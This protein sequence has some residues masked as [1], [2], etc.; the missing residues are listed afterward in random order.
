MERRGQCEHA[1]LLGNCPFCEIQ[2]L[3]AVNRQLRAEF[4]AQEH[5]L[6]AVTHRLVRLQNEALE[7]MEREM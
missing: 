6:R 2:R 1:Y 3:R 7:R 5:E 4:L